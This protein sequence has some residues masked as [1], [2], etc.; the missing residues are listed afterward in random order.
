[1]NAMVELQKAV[2]ATLSSAPALQA[3]IGVGR[4]FDHV[5]PSIAFPYVTFGQTAIYDWST[6]TEKG[7]E[8][9]FTLHAWSKGKGK[10]EVMAVIAAIG[11][12]LD[13]A[14]PAPAGFH[15]INLR[16]EY[17]EARYDEDLGGYH[18]LLRYR[19][20]TEPVA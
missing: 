12:R 20:I 17:S 14:P 13:A 7:N 8:H 4:I 11:E 10:D 16:L 6:S 3:L 15:L 1:M 9:L 2:L 5:P 19:A 18:G